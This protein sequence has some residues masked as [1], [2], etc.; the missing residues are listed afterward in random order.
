MA[1]GTF[2]NIHL[3]NKLLNGEVGQNMTNIL[4]GDKLCIIDAARVAKEDIVK[5]K[6]EA[7]AYNNHRLQVHDPTFKE[8]QPPQA[9]DDCLL[10]E[11]KFVRVFDIAALPS[12]DCFAF[13]SHLRGRLL[14]WPRIHNIARVPGDDVI[15]ELAELVVNHPNEE[16]DDLRLVLAIPSAETLGEDS[17]C[18]NWIA[19]RII[20]T[21]TA[22]SSGVTPAI[23]LSDITQAWNKQHR[24]ATTKKRPECINQ[25]RKKHRRA[26]LPNTVLIDSIYEKNFLSLSSVLEAIIVDAYL[27]TDQSVVMAPVSMVGGGLI[28]KVLKKRK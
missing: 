9:Y 24:D 16:E 15:D 20:K 17:S 22:Y 3:P 6:D 14:N 26:K 10:N 18:W 7:K 28:C 11:D 27:L 23:L 12:K 8:E 19:S 5:L 13:E 2:A 21:C 1:R 25:L 4:T